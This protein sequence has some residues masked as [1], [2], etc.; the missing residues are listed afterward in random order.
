MMY[1]YN[2]IERYIHMQ[3]E[4][5]N[6]K[7]VIKI[8]VMWFFLLV[9]I[10][11]LVLAFFKNNIFATNETSRRE[12]QKEEIKF[13]QNENQIDV[14]KLM[15]ENNYTDSKLVN[16]E[17]KIKYET[18]QKETKNLPKGE[19]EVKQKGKD[20]KNQVTALQKYANDK[21]IEEQVI[22]N[23][24]TKEPVTEIVYVGTSEFLSKYSV[25][26]GD[27]MYLIEISD[28]TEEPK[29]DAKKIESINRY[30]NVELKEVVDNDWIKV[31]YNS[32][33]GYIKADKLTSE[34]V[35]PM[36]TEKNRIAKLQANL[37][38]DMDLSKPSGLT[39]S[40]YKTIFAYNASDTNNIFAENA[41]AFYNAEQT[42]GINGIFLAAIGIHESAWGT[43]KIAK[44]KNNLFGYGA[45]DRDP[46]GCANMFETYA[47]AI[48][49]VA[50]ALEK[51]YLSETG[52]FYN[53]TTAE[54]VNKRYASDKE[55][56][57]KVY[58]YM[59]YLYNKLG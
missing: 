45:Y 27:K 30:L 39:L 47:D 25:H 26:L 5:R 23:N 33:E 42:Y 52:S 22:E 57:N 17:R 53:G 1:M 55:W 10:V 9:F 48:N 13:E 46:E 24:I 35:T 44:N 38:E 41:E 59:Q 56:H 20:G 54:S 21:M 37:S 40:D 18:I 49:T 28:L 3:R 58:K 6:G 31:K 34:A 11:A 14:L 4:L 8:S 43:S 16:E 7:I 32:K 19:K 2:N 12:E 36:I 51:N 29:E 50:E 15:V